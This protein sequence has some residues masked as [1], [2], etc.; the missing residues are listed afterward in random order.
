M[1]ARPELAA[2]DTGAW[3]EPLLRNLAA[4]RFSYYGAAAPG[5][6]PVW[7]ARWPVGTTIPQLVRLHVDFARGDSRVWPDLIVAPRIEADA[8]CVYDDATQACQGRR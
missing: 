2:G 8:G 7:Q 4:V 1:H 6:Q 3:S 5:G